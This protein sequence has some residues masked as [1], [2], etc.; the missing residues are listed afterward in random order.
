MH[1]SFK[2]AKAARQQGCTWC[3]SHV[4]QQPSYHEGFFTPSLRAEKRGTNCAA[5]D[6]QA[7]VAR[8]EKQQCVAVVSNQINTPPASILMLK[9]S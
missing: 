6:V 5:S 4:H 7:G 3:L 9:L 1:L 2:E 8:G